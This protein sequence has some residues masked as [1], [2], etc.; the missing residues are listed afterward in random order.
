MSRTVIGC[1]WTEDLF[2]F[3]FSLFEAEQN[4]NNLKEAAEMQQGYAG[5]EAAGG[6]GA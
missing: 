6:R 2:F 3:L 4:G 1:T 5:G